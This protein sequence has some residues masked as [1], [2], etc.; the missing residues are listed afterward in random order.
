ML[1]KWTHTVPKIALAGAMLMMSGCPGPTSTNP[2]TLPTDPLATCAVGNSEI[3]GWF[4]SGTVVTD[5][6]VNPANSVTFSNNPN[7]DFYK[8]RSRCSCG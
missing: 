3:A 1:N 7:C 5:G 2:Q 6:V 4:Q 8:C